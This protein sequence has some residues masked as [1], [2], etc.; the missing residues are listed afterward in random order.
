[1]RCYHINPW[2]HAQAHMQVL[3]TP[4]LQSIW[5]CGLGLAQQAGVPS[6]MWGAVLSVCPANNAPCPPDRMSTDA[7]LGLAGPKRGPAGPA[8]RS[9]RPAR[10]HADPVEAH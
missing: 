6:K 2:A 9:L 5:A 10:P 1:M 8:G 7:R 4:P 3:I